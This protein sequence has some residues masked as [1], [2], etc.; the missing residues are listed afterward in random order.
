[1]NQAN[2]G[3]RITLSDELKVEMAQSQRLLD[4]YRES[5][6]AIKANNVW[7]PYVEAL[8]KKIRKLE[9]KIQQMALRIAETDSLFESDVEGAIGLPAG[10]N[11]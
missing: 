6:C 9:I 1:M 8:R 11:G 4:V 5:L 3:L 2:P 10:E 7:G